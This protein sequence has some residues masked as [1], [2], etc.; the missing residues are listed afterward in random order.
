MDE[1]RR[2]AEEAKRVS[3]D[4]GL[5]VLELRREQGLTQ[6]QLAERSRLDA[7]DVRRVEAGKNTTVHTLVRLADAFG[8]PVAS[9][10]QSPKLRSVRRPGRPAAGTTTPV[11]AKAPKQRR[12]RTKT[13]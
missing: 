5:R 7:R 10:F 3:I 11:T 9:L 2:V 8:V 4:L 13:S 6:E 12:R 1:A